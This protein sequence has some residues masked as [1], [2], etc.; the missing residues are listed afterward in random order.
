MYYAFAYE[1]MAAV[2][3]HAWSVGKLM[4]EFMKTYRQDL[5]SLD[6]IK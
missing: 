6:V 1:D 3:T 4:D 5:I 2:K